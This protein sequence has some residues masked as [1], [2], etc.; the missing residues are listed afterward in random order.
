MKNLKTAFAIVLGAAFLFG[1]GKYEEGPGISLRTK[2][3]RLTGEWELEEFV[4]DNENFTSDFNFYEIEF[5]NDNEFT[6]RGQVEGFETYTDEG[7][8]DFSGD[9]EE[10]ELEY[11]DGDRVDF[12]IIR[13]T[14]S[15]LWVETDE[16]FDFDDNDELIELK[17]TKK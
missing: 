17:F 1:C 9:K 14:N 6:E 15:E 8:W 7:D 11:D 3:M 10:L 4:V 12:K 2:K 16:D 5:T 13:L